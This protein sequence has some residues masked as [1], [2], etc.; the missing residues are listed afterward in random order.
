MHKDT[1]WAKQIISMQREDGAWGD[2]HTLSSSSNS[3]LTMERALRRL[4]RLGFK[5]KMNV[6]WKWVYP[7]F[8]WDSPCLPYL[9]ESVSV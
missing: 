8:L 5:S 3:P 1:K 7:I 2:F 4:E 6:W 9:A